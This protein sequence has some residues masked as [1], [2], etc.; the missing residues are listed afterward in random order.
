MRQEFK[1]IAAY[2]SEWILPLTDMLFVKPMLRKAVRKHTDGLKTLGLEN[3]DL[4]K[5]CFF[6][7]NHRDICL[8]AAFLSKILIDRHENR[9]YMG[10]GNNLFGRCW[11]EHYLRFNKA[12]VVIRNGSAREVLKNATILSQYI[13]YIQEQRKGHI[14]LAQREGRA[15]DSNDCTQHAV[16]KMLTMGHPEESFIEAIRALNICPICINY[17]YD[18][19]D[20]LKAWEMQAKRDNPNYK[21]TAEFDI[22]NMRTG[23]HGKKGRVVYCFTPSINPELDAIEKMQLTRNE[24][25]EAVANLIDRHIHLHYYDFKRDP[26]QFAQYIESR[27]QMINIPNKDESFLR[28]KLMEMYERPL[29]NKRDALTQTNNPNND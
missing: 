19:C 4:K 3:I 8:D 14:W 25:I 17:E 24:Q 12:F 29:A 22:L 15:K 11:I 21:K 16:L 10:V 13:R 1:K 20:Y 26:K 27:I 28:E 9:P 23:I 5:P 6:M 18:P 7:S 2:R